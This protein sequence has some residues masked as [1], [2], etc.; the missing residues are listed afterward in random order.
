MLPRLRGGRGR[1]NNHS[2][3]TRITDIG[4][5]H[6]NLPDH[7]EGTNDLSFTRGKHMDS[8]SGDVASRAYP[9]TPPPQLVPTP[10]IHAPPVPPDPQPA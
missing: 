2:Y 7:P 10:P 1:S 5:P 4:Q 3:V 8:T 9:A 6:R